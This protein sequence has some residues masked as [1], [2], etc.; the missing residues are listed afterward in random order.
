[1]NNN[2]EY[3]VSEIQNE[4]FSGKDKDI[5][6][7]KRCKKEIE[8]HKE[9]I[10]K[11]NKKIRELE[12][13]LIELYKREIKKYDEKIKELESELNSFMLVQN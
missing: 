6:L 4:L 1:M 10:K 11:H 5:T 9:E 3:V 12:D 8:S 2:D 13:R 7:L